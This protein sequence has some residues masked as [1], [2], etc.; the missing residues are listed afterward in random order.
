MTDGRPR[1]WDKELA[2]IDK[3]TRR[4]AVGRRAAGADRRCRRR[5]ASGAPPRRAARPAAEPGSVGAHLAFWTRC[6]R[7]ALGVG[8]AVLAVSASACGLQLVVYLGAAV[9][10][11][12]RG[13]WSAVW[14]WRHR[15]R[16]RPL[17]SL[18][19]CSGR[20]CSAR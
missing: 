19:C 20:W 4:Q 16:A 14:T 17:L 1:D 18:L 8:I 13:V 7:V 5:R 2:K 11:G 9:G 12:G 3:A 6:S 15:A 10:R